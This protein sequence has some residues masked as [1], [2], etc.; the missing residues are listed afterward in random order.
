MKKVHVTLGFFIQSGRFINTFVNFFI[1]QIRTNT[2]RQWFMA[3]RGA[4]RPYVL[5]FL[6]I[7]IAFGLLACLPTANA[8]SISK[9]NIVVTIKPI[10][11]LVR[12]IAKDTVNIQRLLPDYASPHHYHFRPSDIRKVKAANLIFRIDEGLER[13]VAPLF[14]TLPQQTIISL[15]DLPEIKWLA[16]SKENKDGED[17]HHHDAHDAHQHGDQDFHL[18]MSPHNGIVMATK[19]TR[20]L[21]QLNPQNRLFYQKNLADL[22]QKIQKFTN[23]FHSESQSFQN[24]PYL[25]FHDSWNYFSTTFHLPKLASINLHADI[26]TGVKTI[27]QTRRK[28][29]Q[30]QAQCLFSEPLFRPKTIA[31]LTEGFPIK[32]IELDTLGSHLK[33]DDDLYIE[34][35]RY[36]AR[37]IKNCLSPQ[38]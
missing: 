23:R 26:Q 20:E 3:D 16:I 18:W 17:P 22:Q 29:K 15:A 36:T 2:I 19:I 34:L 11:G 33:S 14:Q 13:F 35:L 38:I 9:K 12:A 32:T 6:N 30:S 7:L 24:K 37:Q 31:I 4:Y 28:I 27:M 21:S 25:V 8:E 5:N 10:E 1:T